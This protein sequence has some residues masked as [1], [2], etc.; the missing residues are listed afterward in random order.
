MASPI[1]PSLIG[2]KNAFT[3]WIK[4][5]RA[6]VE[7]LMKANDSKEQSS[8]PAPAPEL[9]EKQACLR[10]KL[11]RQR[12]REAATREKHQKLAENESSRRR[13]K[14]RKK[15]TEML[16]AAVRQSNHGGFRVGSGRKPDYFRKLGI[17]P[18][19]A[20]QLLATIDVPRIVADLVNDKN[21]ATRLQMLSLLWNR[22]F[23]LPRST[24]EIEV[25]GGP[26]MRQALKSCLSLQRMERNSHLNP[27]PGHYLKA[28]P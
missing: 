24:G 16:D 21:P 13:R 5:Q 1:K 2:S 15:E 11:D 14:R 4:N 6:E 28:L 12:E 19:S 10:E 26:R 8:K 7:G 23:G 20:A 18:L 17:P 22:V 27:A 25:S 9:T 3:I